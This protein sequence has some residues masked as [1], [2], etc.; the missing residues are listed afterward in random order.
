MVRLYEVFESTV[1]LDKLLNVHPVFKCFDGDAVLFKSRLNEYQYSM[2]MHHGGWYNYIIIITHPIPFGT[3]ISIS[4]IDQSE[5]KMLIRSVVFEGKAL[6]NMAG[7]DEKHIPKKLIEFFP[8]PC[9][10]DN[11][12]DYLIKPTIKCEICENYFC[13]KHHSH[14][15]ESLK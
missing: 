15:C 10:K 4:I 9:Y 13:E 6:L 8:H 12:Y 2:I 3:E 5:T 1:G 14:G 7:R 11:D